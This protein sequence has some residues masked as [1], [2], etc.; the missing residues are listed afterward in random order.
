MLYYKNKIYVL[1]VLYIEVIH[2]H[3]DISLASYFGK[4]QTI[5]SLCRNFQWPN[6]VRNIANYTKA[7]QSYAINKPIIHTIYKYLLLLFSSGSLQQ[8]IDMDMI[9]NL[10]KIS[11]TSY[12]CI[13]VVINYFIKISHF[14]PCKKSLNTEQT[15]NLLM[16][17]V[18]RHHGLPLTIV[19]NKD[20]YWINEFW[21]YLDNCLK[22]KQAPTIVQRIQANRQTKRINIILES[23]LKVY[24]N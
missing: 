11:K 23:Y 6:L 21:K 13:L 18:I 15:T 20:K 4:D 9:T 7:C 22:I 2:L 16:D 14:V 10:P 12:D 19:S 5:E 24:Y 3:Y 1:K 17:M 8:R